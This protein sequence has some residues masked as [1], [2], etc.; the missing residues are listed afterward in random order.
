MFRPQQLVA[1]GRDAQL[2]LA[3]LETPVAP[4]R[5]P[6][7]GGQ[8][9]FLEGVFTHYGVEHASKAEALTLF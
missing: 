9:E 1:I 3:E 6:S 5:H 2:A 8:R 4:V 7:Y